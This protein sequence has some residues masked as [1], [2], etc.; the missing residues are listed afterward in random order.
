M[1]YSPTNMISLPFTVV[2]SLGI[3]F[4]WVA[5]PG[6]ATQSVYLTDSA[7]ALVTDSSSQCVQ[8]GSWNKALSTPECDAQLAEQERLDR[9]AELAAIEAMKKDPALIRISDTGKVAFS[10]NSSALTEST[11][12]EL[13][14][15]VQMLKKYADVES[16]DIAGH[17]DNTGPEVYNQVLSEIGRNQ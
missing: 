11:K 14:H 6:Y 10:F 16:I 8:T 9:Q 15:V 17:T 5:N 12:S 7:G 4:L 2:I 3:A 13:D 1:T